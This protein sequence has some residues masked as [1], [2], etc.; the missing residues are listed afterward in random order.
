MMK[1]MT[2]DIV[3]GMDISTDTEFK[4]IKSDKTYYFCSTNCQE[5]FEKDPHAYMHQHGEDE[6]CSSCKPLEHASMAKSSTA[7]KS[8]AIYTCPM[9]P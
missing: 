2:L 1:N 3:C 6:N 7:E 4:T 5:K 9:H 8:D